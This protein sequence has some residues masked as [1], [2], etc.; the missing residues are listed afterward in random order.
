MTDHCIRCIRLL[1]SGSMRI[2]WNVR[3]S[4]LYLADGVTL[5]IATS[6]NEIIIT[7]VYWRPGGCH[8]GGSN[9]TGHYQCPSQQVPA[10]L[11][12]HRSHRIVLDD[13]GNDRPI[14]DRFTSC[15]SAPP[16]SARVLNLIHVC[17]VLHSSV[18]AT[19]VLQ[20]QPQLPRPRL[21]GTGWVSRQTCLRM[22]SYAVVR[23]TGLW[24]PNGHKYAPRDVFR[25]G[26]QLTR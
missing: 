5:H 17:G 4:S 1:I 24:T 3:S 14:D 20:I 21:G 9:H 2:A 18:S 25:G 16:R 23:T 7:R 19:V 15:V 13:H 10:S 6:S 26:G 11:T 12:A 8:S 22:G